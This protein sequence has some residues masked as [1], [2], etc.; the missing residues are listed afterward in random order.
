MMR[1]N[2]LLG[3]LLCFSTMFYSGCTKTENGVNIEPKI[4][5]AA[6]FA[7]SAEVLARLAVQFAPAEETQKLALV[8]R[9]IVSVI[10][11]SQGNV[12][13]LIL[14]TADNA[15]K[16]GL[17]PEKY[18][19][20]IQAVVVL[21]DRYVNVVNYNVDDVIVIVEGALKGIETVGIKSVGQETFTW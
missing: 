12:S 10:K 9:E 2:C 18:K 7:T 1:K 13:G 3:L 5:H 11:N 6:E 21:I 20:F 16:N 17:L 14:S 4:P 8:L 19:I 15:V